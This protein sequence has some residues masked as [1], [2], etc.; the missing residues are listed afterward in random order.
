ML[1]EELRDKKLT[2]S[3]L[4]EPVVLFPQITKNVRVTDKNAAINDEMLLKK[5]EEINAE[6]GRNGRA[7]LRASGTEPVLRIMLE[8]ESK[9][10]CEKYISTLYSIVK[11]RGYC[12]E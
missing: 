9:E 1:T 6:L 10:K 11:K 8:C 3:K 5:C 4:S 7:V 2:L 12:C